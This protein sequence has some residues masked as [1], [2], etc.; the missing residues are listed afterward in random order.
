MEDHREACPKCR[1]A[2]GDTK[3]DN[4]IVYQD[5]AAHC[6]ACGH[7]VFP[8]DSK[9]TPSYRPRFKKNTEAASEGVHAAISDRK[10]SK[11]IATKYKVKVEYGANGQII[12]HHYPF[13]DKSCRITAW[14]TRD[15][16]TKGFHISGSFKDVGLF[17]E[18]LWDA[19]GKYLTITEGEID[20]R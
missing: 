18:C 12:K 7:H 9:S 16:A 13:T 14:K 3:G 11:D 15:V 4:L 17:G 10:I 20:C 6:F 5:G 2:G 8:D 19:G 1:E